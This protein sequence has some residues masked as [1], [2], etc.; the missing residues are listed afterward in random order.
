MPIKT[1]VA[2]H[3]NILN[4]SGLSGKSITALDWWRNGVVD[5]IEVGFSG[6]TVFLKMRNSQFEY[7]G[8]GNWGTGTRI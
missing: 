4:V 6:G 2:A 7:G 3:G 8:D 1:D 5:V